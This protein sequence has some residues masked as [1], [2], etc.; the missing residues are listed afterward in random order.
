[1]DKDGRDALNADSAGEPTSAGR[2]RHRVAGCTALGCTGVLAFGAMVGVGLANHNDAT[3]E[4]DAG[5]VLMLP[6]VA[7]VLIAGCSIAYRIWQP[8]Q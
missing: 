3:G 6:A 1:M 8:K 4:T 5:N 2:A 7:F